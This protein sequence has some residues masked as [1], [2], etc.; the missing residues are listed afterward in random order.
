MTVDFTQ[1][2]ALL[3]LLVLPA[4]WLIDRI[5]RTHLPRQR[6]RLV[7]G[8]RI[9]IA[10][11]LILGLAGPRVIGR[12]D[13]QAVAFLVDKSDSVTPPMQERQQAFLRDATSAMTDRDRATIIAFGAQSTVDRP[14]STARPIAPITS[15]VDGGKTD[16][17]GAIRLALATLPST[18]ARKIVILSDGNE[19]TGKA[20]EQA[21]VAQAAGVP[22]QVV[23]LS[24]QSGPEV[25]VRQLE[26]PAFVREGER[27]SATLTLE[28]SQDTQ[29]RVLL[30]ADGRLLASQNANLTQGSNNIVLPQEP[31]PPGFHLFSVQVEA[32]A[33]T[34]IQNNEGGSYTVVTGKPRVLL[35][36]S[37][38][39]ETQYLAQALQSAGLEVE[40]R[41]T[42]TAVIDLPTLRGYESV[43]LANV[44]AADLSVPQMR[45]INSYVQNLGG[46]L[47][48]VGGE[49]SYGVGRYNRTPLEEALPVR[50]DLRGRTLT[51]S[52]ALELVI[53][54]SG[55]MA[56][57]PGSSKMDLAKEAAIRAT[58]LLSEQDQ[59]G[60][61]SFDDTPRWVVPTA[62]LEDMQ[63]VQ[64]QIGSIAPG[65]GTAIFPALET[66][67]NDIVTR[68]AKVRH[69][70]LLTDGLSSGG[71]YDRLTAQMA[72]NNI[73]LST[74][75]VGSDADFQLMQRL[76]SLG[77]GR[78]FEGND[79]FEVPQ[80]IVKD[81]QEVARAAIVEE[82]FKPTQ[83][84]ASPMLDGIDVS[85]MPPLLGYVST[86]PKPTSQVLLVSNQVD[87]VLSEWQFGLGH[88]VAWTSD[89]KNRWA[90]DWLTWPEFSQFWSQVVKR[91]IPV[92]VDRNLQV[93]ITPEGSTARVTVDS[94]SDDKAYQNF[95]KTSATV[96]DPSNAQSQITLPQVAPG[97]YETHIPIGGEG[98]Y[99]LNIMQSDANGTVVGA[100]PAGFVVPY[101]Q[102]YR[103]LRA[104]PDLL[105]QLAGLTGGRV[106]EDPKSV[107]DRDR[108]VDGQP[109]ELWPWLMM[110]AV[111][112]FMFDVAARRLR[113][114][115]M[116]AERA[117]S[118]V[119][120]TWLGRARLAAAPAAARLLAAKGRISIEA[121]GL[122]AGRR[123]AAARNGPASAGA[124]VT[125]SSRTA[126][127]S[128]LGARLLD[129]KK[130]AGPA[131]TPTSAPPES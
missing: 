74:I 71:D 44:P 92:P 93:Q 84:G 68:E 67:Y 45:A 89:V 14:L 126:S 131:A 40:V 55:S 1:P 106:V 20:L 48:V 112:L 27:F 46:G 10:A 4:F 53:D 90:Q 11:L 26:T 25:L 24:Q 22:I 12:A 127:S 128:A 47:V 72:A 73:T 54:A 5:S 95:L 65:G 94:V 96:V 41:S 121:G 114:G 107:F 101:S 105:G 111:L 36:E 70:L 109:R 37:Q 122:A 7:L 87:P 49:Q 58:E 64:A 42:Q 43:V 75:A 120:D 69:I 60:V 79:P 83:V 99:F 33:D 13:E 91:T 52:V 80:M 130:R 32:S 76:A 2:L 77:K 39:G 85:Q 28:A 18:M 129:A 118:Y 57:G 81:T 66:A 6:R 78:Y 59:L 125:G 31:L 103:D 62:F 97:R 8:V 63:A 110:L 30:L 88:V 21:R 29:A 3:L 50:M 119:L 9:A 38:A 123:G 15:V 104:N 117:W 34:Y 35:I 61:I 108:R 86:T 113:L 16:I 116:D 23:P 98:A 51:A 115:W 17:A 100:R 19:N 102:E 124:A 82:P 56:G